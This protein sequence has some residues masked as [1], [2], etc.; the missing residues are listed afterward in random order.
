MAIKEITDCQNHE[1]C[2]IC[3]GCSKSK[4]YS[5]VECDRCGER[6]DDDEEV[7]FLQGKQYHDMCVL[8][9][10]DSKIAGCLV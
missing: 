10:L 1:L 3:T 8:E 2:E 6:F 5:V 4:P 9:V 7:Y